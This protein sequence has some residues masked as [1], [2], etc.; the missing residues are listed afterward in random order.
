MGSQ[1]PPCGCA[2]PGSARAENCYCGV[3]DLLQVLRKRYSLLVLR[4]VD[5]RGEAR[6]HEVAEALP[7][8]SSSTLADTLRALERARLLRRE[9]ESAAR[10]VY[11][12][13]R[14]GRK[15][16]SRLRVLLEDVQAH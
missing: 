16:L 1:I 5:A 13:T 7:E 3:E 14:S 2:Q 6:Y 11:S 10:P 8:A 9:G 4:A 12:L 15:L